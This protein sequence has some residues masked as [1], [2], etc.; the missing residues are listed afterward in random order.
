MTFALHADQG[1]FTTQWEGGSGF[2]RHAKKF[3]DRGVIAEHKIKQSNGNP[4]III[5]SFLLG[6]GTKVQYDSEEW[7]PSK[8]KPS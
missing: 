8:W 3:G 4:L 2:S 6:G 5:N 7:K 1:Q